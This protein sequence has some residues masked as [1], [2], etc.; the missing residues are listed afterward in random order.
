MAI[1]KI[2]ATLLCKCPR[3]RKGDMFTNSPFN[4]K[5]GRRLYIHC[6]ACNLKFEREP[7]FFEGGMYFNYAMNV[8]ILVAS[9]IA[10]FVLLDDPNEFVYFGVSASMVVLMVVFT[11]RLS[12]SLMLHLFGGVDFDPGAVQ[13]FE[14]AESKKNRTFS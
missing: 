13:G 12:K 3:C 11:S 8:A 6:P 1:S 7:A 14:D 4:L 5:T 2:Q 10:T 9:G